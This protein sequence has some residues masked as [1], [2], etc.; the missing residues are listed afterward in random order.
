MDH[1]PLADEFIAGLVR[2]AP[3]FSVTVQR[4]A[5]ERPE[6]FYPLGERMLGW[7][8]AQLGESW[9]DTLIDAYVAFVIDVNRSQAA[10][11]KRGRYEFSSYA[12]VFKAV[13]G[14]PEFMKDYHWG[15]FVTTFAWEHHLSIFEF[16]HR[17]FLAPLGRLQGRGR[18]L[19]LGCGS[20]IWSLT[21]L[22]DLP[23][24]SSTMVDISET[25]VALTAQTIRTAGYS[26]RTELHCRDALAPAAGGPYDAAVSFFL[27]E[28]LEAPRLLLRTLAGAVPAGARVFITTA[29][30]A[31][32]TD[33][34]Y[35]FRRESEVLLLAEEAGFRVVAS[36]SATPLVDRGAARYI[37][38]SM[39]LSLQKRG[40]EH[41]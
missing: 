27:L 18:L 33:H 28:H 19:D 21:A 14:D 37:P 31:A 32:E 38:R 40:D 4:T 7:A 29:L 34:I 2:A 25:T 39:A 11:E 8:K 35:E 36:L 20:G 9:I 1:H 26:A 15:V 17:T 13:Y 12:D 3:A 22:G 5:S 41:F 30:T 10:Y 16:F 23:G 6:L 24:W